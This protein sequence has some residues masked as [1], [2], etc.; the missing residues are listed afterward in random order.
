MGDR[1]VDIYIDPFR[2]H[3][4]GVY[5]E[6]EIRGIHVDELDHVRGEH[7][8]AVERRGDLAAPDVDKDV[9]ESPEVCLCG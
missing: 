3:R 9:V 6:A 2:G 4:G 8:A 7:G 1:D 5:A